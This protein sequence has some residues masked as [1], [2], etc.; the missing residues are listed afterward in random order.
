ML[1][2]V[3]YGLRSP[4]KTTLG[5]ALNSLGAL[6]VDMGEFAKARETIA[7]STHIHDVAQPTITQLDSLSG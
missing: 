1:E 7:R 2:A 4:S 5:Y 3:P 6:Y